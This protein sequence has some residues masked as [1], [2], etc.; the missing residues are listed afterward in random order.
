MFKNIRSSCHVPLE[1]YARCGSILIQLRAVSSHLIMEIENIS[2][3]ELINKLLEQKNSENNELK[4]LIENLAEREKEEISLSIKNKEE[5][6]NPDK[7]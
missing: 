6:E 2:T 1:L 4:K 3:Q 5:A 7:K